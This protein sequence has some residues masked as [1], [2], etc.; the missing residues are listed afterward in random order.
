MEQKQGNGGN[1]E[2]M[3]NLEHRLQCECVKWVRMQHRNVLIFAIPNGGARTALTGAM[4]KAEGV[5][6]GVPDLFIAHPTPKYSGLFVEM[7]IKPNKP[8]N[9]Q[10]DAMDRLRN[11]GYKVE[12]CYSFDEFVRCVTD[13]LNCR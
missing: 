7:K 5:V 12:V 3:K 13:Y 2:N 8:S 6:A 10:V 1:A 4:L 9:A 11:V